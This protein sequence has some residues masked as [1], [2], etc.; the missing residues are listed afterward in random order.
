MRTI[1]KY[2]TGIRELDN[3]I[4]FTMPE[5]ARVLSV[6]NQY[7]KLCLWVEVND[8]A[9]LESRSFCIRGTGHPFTGYEGK[10]LGS[11][12]FMDGALV[13][14]VYDVTNSYYKLQGRIKWNL[15][16]Y[17]IQSTMPLTIC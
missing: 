8:S 4:G 17:L 5:G 12:I 2:S 3:T 6:G 11:A 1:W 14:H 13:F 7:E 10:F 15:E 9:E 16:D